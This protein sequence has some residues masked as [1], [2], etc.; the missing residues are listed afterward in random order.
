VQYGVSHSER[1]WTNPTD[2]CT[3]SVSVIHLEIISTIGVMYEKTSQSL[4][5]KETVGE[6]SKMVHKS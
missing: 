1:N 5:G 2:N 6:G 4:K 3:V